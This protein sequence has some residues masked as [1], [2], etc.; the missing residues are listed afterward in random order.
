[1][2]HL[3]VVQPEAEADM[4][5]VFRELEGISPGL[6][7]RFLDELA[8]LFELL[9]VYPRGFQK[10]RGGIPLGLFEALSLP[11]GLPRGSWACIHLQDCPPAPPA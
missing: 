9:E 10:R 1:M 4:D 7:G 2:R 6:G 3:L 8:D 11:R 5:E